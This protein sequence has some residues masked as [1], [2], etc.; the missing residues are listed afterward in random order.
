[1]WEWIAGLITGWTWLELAPV[2]GLP[3]LSG[4]RYWTQAGASKDWRRYVDARGRAPIQSTV[5]FL[6]RNVVEA[7]LDGWTVGDRATQPH[8]TERRPIAL[9]QVKVWEEVR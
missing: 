8:L 3:V 7:W 9:R 1:M 2:S 6:R 5:V 4:R